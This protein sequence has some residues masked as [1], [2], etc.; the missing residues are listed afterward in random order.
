MMS[1]HIWTRADLNPYGCTTVDLNEAVLVSH[2]GA[3]VL[4]PVGST[5]HNFATCFWY[6]VRYRIRSSLR[7]AYRA[8]CKETFYLS[9]DVD[10]L[11]P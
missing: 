10:W 9:V 6:R 4:I 11:R 1:F 5:T 7:E 3:Y 2:L 8:S